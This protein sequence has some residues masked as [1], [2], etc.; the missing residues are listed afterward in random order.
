MD[1]LADK[2]ILLSL[3]NVDAITDYLDTFQAGS[4]YYPAIFAK[5]VI[6]TEYQELKCLQIYRVSVYATQ[7]LQPITY[8]INCRD[9]TESGSE[10]LAEIVYN[11]INRKITSTYSIQC[12]VAQCI[13]E[14]DNHYNT[15][16][17]VTIN[18][19]EH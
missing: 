9:N 11:E 14:D 10:E 6:P 17:D 8:T 15:P 7:E 3:L 19:K 4:S 18:N 12:R 5:S 2:K 16:I 13:Y 1:R